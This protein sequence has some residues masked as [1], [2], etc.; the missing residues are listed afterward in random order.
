MNIQTILRALDSEVYDLVQV[1]RVK[2]DSQMPAEYQKGAR[3]KHDDWAVFKDTLRI[4][5]AYRPALPFKQISGVKRRK[6]ILWDPTYP[7]SPGHE[8]FYKDYYTSEG[9]FS[10]PH[11]TVDDAGPGW[12][13]F[14]VYINGEWVPCFKQYHDVW[15]GK[16]LSYY[17][18]GLKQDLTVGFNKDWSLRSDVM[19][20][21]D[22]PSASWIKES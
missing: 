19:A 3:D 16:R 9:K 18:G 17:S 10:L 1:Y 20:W 5:T 12:A 7:T 6:D 8:I 4:D 21:W 13:T 2:D 22:P 15:F 11:I 14:A